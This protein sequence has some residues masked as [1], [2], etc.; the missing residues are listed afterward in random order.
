ML[1]HNK[2]R[3]VHNILLFFKCKDAERINKKPHRDGALEESR[4]GLNSYAIYYQGG[5][6]DDSKWY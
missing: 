1:L 4:W 3:S 5:Q 2:K 6:N